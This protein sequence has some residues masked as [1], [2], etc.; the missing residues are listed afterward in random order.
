M[1]F[2]RLE[3]VARASGAMPRLKTAEGPIDC[4]IMVTLT[5]TLNGRPV[6]AEI[7]GPH[8]ISGGSDLVTVA[9]GLVRR[10]VTVHAGPTLGGGVASF[11]DERIALA[12]LLEVMDRGGQFTGYEPSAPQSAVL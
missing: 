3:R 10:G 11:E 9:A 5:G 7:H 4:P 1:A 2:T 12:T 6:Q 8:D